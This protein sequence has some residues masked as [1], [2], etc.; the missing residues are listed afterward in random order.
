MN[1]PADYVCIM[2]PASMLWIVVVV[3]LLLVVVL[4]AIS[5]WEKLR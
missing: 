5:V 3:T 4:V 1:C 2:Y